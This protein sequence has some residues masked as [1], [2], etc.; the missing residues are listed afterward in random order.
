MSEFFAGRNFR[1]SL[2]LGLFAFLFSRMSTG[3]RL[4]VMNGDGTQGTIVYSRGKL[5]MFYFSE[6]EVQDCSLSQMPTFEYESCIRGYHVYQTIWSSGIGEVL[7]CRQEPRKAE[8][9]FATGVY[10]GNRPLFP[11]CPS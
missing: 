4:C 3:G 10:K 1:E 11:R 2:D 8:N 9:P 5:L 6:K 7:S